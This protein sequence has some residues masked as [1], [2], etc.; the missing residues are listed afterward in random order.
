LSETSTL[1][2]VAADPEGPE[3]GR[4]KGKMEIRRGR[5]LCEEEL[6]GSSVVDPESES[7]VDRTDGSPSWQ[8][9]KAIC[10]ENFAKLGVRNV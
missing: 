3:A 9:L 8:Q 7:V 6:L 10:L 1:S 5:G 2:L 4:G